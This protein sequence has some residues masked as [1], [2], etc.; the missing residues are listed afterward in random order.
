MGSMMF[1]VRPAVTRAPIGIPG[2][3]L[4]GSGARRRIR[5]MEPDPVMQETKGTEIGPEEEWP[6]PRPPI[7]LSLGLARSNDVEVAVRQL[8]VR[9]KVREADLGC[10]SGAI[11]VVVEIDRPTVVD[12]PIG[13]IRCLAAAR[14]GVRA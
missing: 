3:E 13:G 14:E 12:D 9:S 5:R 1:R 10:G 7:P 2:V 11:A 6:E 4:S 8:D